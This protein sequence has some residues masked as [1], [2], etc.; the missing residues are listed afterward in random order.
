MLTRLALLLRT[1]LIFALPAAA[2]A[3][4]DQT[5]NDAPIIDSVEAP[6]VV[7]EQNGEYAIPVTVL[8]HDNDGEAVTRIHY[9]LPPSVDGYLDVPAP[10]PTRESALITIVIKTAEL[11]R[12]VPEVTVRGSD[13][14]HAAADRDHERRGRDRSRARALH[15][16]IVD[17]RG[18][19][20]L[21][22]SSTVT[23][24]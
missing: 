17:G 4:G 13:G 23:L 21:P 14:D 7:S 3:C 22:Q 8:F 19:E 11:D 9:R 18:A 6:L 16:S 10:N 12:D 20:S 5:A 2:I 1:G 24:Q 15:L